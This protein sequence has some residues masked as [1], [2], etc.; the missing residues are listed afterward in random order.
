MNNKFLINL[1]CKLP[2]RLKRKVMYAI[3]GDR[4]WV[5]GRQELGIAMENAI[6]TFLTVEELHDS[7]RVNMLK[8]DMRKCFL[9]YGFK[10]SEYF[11]FGLEG[12]DNAYRSG[13]LSEAQEDNLLQKITGYDKYLTDLTDKYHFYELAKP[14][15]KRAVML[16]DKQ[17]GKEEFVSYC[18]K[19]KDLFI[20]PLAGSEG[21]GA[22]TFMIINKDDAERLFKKLA[23]TKAKWMVEERIKQSA[24]MNE[25]NESSVNTVRLPSFLNKQG[26][27][28][29]A[30][31]FRTGRAGQIVDNT[32]AD[33]VFALIEPKTGKLVSDGYDI[34]NHIYKLHPDS[35]KVFKDYHIPNWSELIE[36]A[37]SV[38]KT[39]PTHIYIAWD[40][41]LTDKGWDLIEGNWGRFRGAQIAGKKGIRKQFIKYMNGGRFSV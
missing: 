39:F 25:W 21:D 24:E 14:F 16:F 27:H 13:Y 7:A 32:S 15:F 37:E 36:L 1:I 3:D 33:G 22:F 28:V 8:S 35:N 17:T 6:S 26:F 9:D 40:F 2:P 20:K 23:N 30:P 34:N 29:L 5:H 31:I 12:K 38:H 18:L 10:P 4:A 11:H 41:A 19:E